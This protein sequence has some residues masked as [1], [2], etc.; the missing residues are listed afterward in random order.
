M[1]RRWNSRTIRSNVEWAL[2]ESE[3]QKR[4]DENKRLDEWWERDRRRKELLYEFRQSLPDVLFQKLARNFDLLD[5]EKPPAPPPAAAVGQAVP[6]TVTAPPAAA[7]EPSTEPNE[8]S[9]KTNNVA[10]QTE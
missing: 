3:E 1:R 8:P 9:T 2:G 10:T 7:T 5:E 4:K 6:D